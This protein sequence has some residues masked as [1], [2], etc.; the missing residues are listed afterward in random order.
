MKFNRILIAIFTLIIIIKSDGFTQSSDYKVTASNSNFFEV[1][2]YPQ[3]ISNINFV[4]SDFDFDKKGSP[5][6]GFRAFPLFL[7][8]DKNCRTEIIEIKY[9]KVDNIQVKPIPY[10]K[11]GKDKMTENVYENDMSIYGNNA[12]YPSTHINFVNSGILRDK[13][14]GHLKIYPVIYNPVT[15]TAQKISYIKVRVYFEDTPAISQ[16]KY[17][18]EEYAFLAG[19]AYNSH[20]AI[21]W[22]VKPSQILS[23]RSVQNSVLSSGNFHKLEI[24]ETGIYKLDKAY[25]QNAGINTNDI[26]P[27]TFKIYGTDGRMLPFDNAEIVPTDLSEMKI[28]VATDA[29][30]KFEYLL[31]YGK[32]LEDWKFNIF[33]RKY[34]HYINYY[35]YNN[36]YFLSYGGALG[37]RVSVSNSTNI[38]NIPPLSYFMDKYFSEPEVLNLGSTGNI[39]L[40]QRI[41]LDGSFNFSRNLPGY[42][43]GSNLFLKIRLGNSTYYNLG[44]F[45]IKDDNSS[46]SNVYPIS[47]VSN[48]FSHITLEELNYQ[49]SLN[50]GATS[51]AL[52]VSLPSQYNYPSAQGHYDYYEVQYSR[53]LNSVSND[54][55]RI[56]APDTLANLEFQVSPFSNSDIRIFDVTEFNSIKIINPISFTN[57]V[58]RFQDEIAIYPKEYIISS[59][60]NFKNP[61]SISP[62]IP[63]QNLG[64]IT[65]GADFI[66][67]SH[68]DFIS[69]AN[70]LKS[71]REAAGKHYL[72]TYVFDINQVFNE[73]SGGL[74]DPLAM[75]NFLKH[76]FINWQIKPV[77]VLFLGD[78]SFDYK[79]IYNL[80]QKNYVP[81]VQKSD[82]QINEISSYVS[83][84]FLVEINESYIEPMPGR[85]DFATGRFTVNSLAE[86]NTMV[87]KIIAYES[88]SSIGN[89]KKKI[90]YV[91][92]DGWTT[93][94]NQGQENSI[95]TDQCE[96]IAEIY[97]PKDF[98]RDKIYIVTYPAIIT[99]QGRRKPGANVDI[100]KGWNDGRLVINYVGHGSTDLWAHEHVFVRDESIPQLTNKNKYPLVTIASCDLARWDD[101]FLISAAE[102]LAGESNKGAIAVI[103]AVRPVYSAPNATFNNYLWNNFM[104]AKDTLNLPIRI[105]RAMY[106]VKNQL[107]SI[108]EN[109]AKFCLVGDPSLRV[110]IPQYFT[111]IDSIN[112][113]ATPDIAE[114]KA[115]QKVKISGRVL[116]PDSTFWSDFNGNIN[117]KV[118][119]VDRQ[120]LLYDFGYPFSFKLDGGNI[121]SGTAKVQNGKWFVEFVVPKDISY[122]NGTGKML[123]YFSDGTNEG[124][125]F[126]NTFIMAGLDSNAAIDTTGPKITLFMDSRNF[127]SGDLVNQNTKI[128]ADFFDENGIN[129]TGTIGHRIEAIINDDESKKIDLTSYYNSTN[130]YREGTLEYPIQNLAEGTYKIKLKAWDTYNNS[131]YS[132]VDFIVKNNSELAFTEVYNFPNPF[133]DVTNFIFQHNSDSPISVNIKIYTVSGRLIRDLNRTNINTKNVNIEW[134]GLDSDGDALANGVYLYKV[135]IK[136]DDGNF[137]KTTLNKLAK[138]K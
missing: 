117:L 84:D 26:D 40:S 131:G 75:R 129:L 78:G 54:F 133:K 92:D 7:S 138:L 37:R 51:S 52:K 20:N 27:A 44:Y 46:F 18:A 120:I 62:K 80:S 35:A 14:Y 105:G 67:F 59:F 17:S 4:N 93:E 113:V 32:S 115:L 82:P 8:S 132:E 95:H 107:P 61:I 86:A 85:P 24:K 57:G 130:S 45:L 110:S 50:P 66:I 11:K 134:D 122:T 74:P 125:G 91:A 5:G 21:N 79:N 124:S 29:S 100:I 60:S 73:F 39:W 94:N 112:N 128:I 71:H 19:A 1:E 87:D 3:Y 81:P 15:S 99:P 43:Q 64:G 48:P 65:D 70:R 25:L 104:F 88:A 6:L 49:Y 28:F 119:D 53:S 69:A 96:T 68:P 76:A 16:R 2:F 77:Y 30:G 33:T 101:P 123:C 10:L 111:K 72:K 102:Q 98:E 34:N 121:F 97:T 63:N 36:V 118:L 9:D 23:P 12:F 127:R 126:N 31:F 47:G 90:M 38:P 136:S 41:G 109:D 108:S 137:S 56:W 42:V 103:A 135:I 22:T 114:L 55:I 89:W 116:R 13:Y 106:N 58:I 83:D